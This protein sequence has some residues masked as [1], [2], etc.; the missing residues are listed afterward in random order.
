MTKQEHLA[1]LQRRHG[2]PQGGNATEA[3]VRA[4]VERRLARGASRADAKAYGEALRERNR[5]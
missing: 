4:M 5:L 1:A 3:W 2:L